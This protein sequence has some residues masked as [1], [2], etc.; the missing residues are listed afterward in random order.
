MTLRELFPQ[1]PV[2]LRSPPGSQ[3]KFGTRSFY[4]DL[5]WYAYLFMNSEMERSAETS[6][7]PEE[8]RRRWH[9]FLQDNKQFLIFH[10]RPLV[11]VYLW[12]APFTQKKSLVLKVNWDLFPDYLEDK[13]QS[14]VSEV[15][16]DG[17]NILKLYR[18]IWINFFGDVERFKEAE[19]LYFYERENFRKLL[20]RTGD[21][22]DL[23]GLL[24]SFEWT[25]HQIEKYAENKNIPYML[26]YTKNFLMDLQHLR[27][28]IDV[29][30]IPPAYLLLRSL[31]ENFVR[32][33]VY[34]RIGEQLDAPNLVLGAM[35]LYEYEADKKQRRYSFDEFKNVFEKKFLK[36][37]KV[38]LSD[39]EI[40]VS[41][42]MSKF[43]EKGIPMLGVN[44]DVLKDFSLKYNVTEANLDKLYSACSEV[45]HNQPPLPFFSLLEVKFFKHF[46][47]KCIGSLLL[48]SERIIYD[49]NHPS[50]DRIH[51]L[52]EGIQIP[53][54]PFDDEKIRFLNECINVAYVLEIEHV[55]EIKNFI[56][57]AVVTLQV[58]RSESADHSAT[59]IRPLSLISLFHIISPSLRRLRD[60]SL[61]EEDLGDIIEIIQTISFKVSIKYEIEATLSKLEDMIS[62]ELERY[63]VFSSLSPEKKKKVIFYLLINNLSRAL[64]ETLRS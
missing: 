23:V 19:S 27:A 62:P 21:Y 30:S 24:I 18:E 3:V 31:L 34:F 37:Q 6:L 15:E 47:G 58:E 7:I 9:E 10:N 20:K 16:N 5:P 48:L 28:L 2:G 25:I 40:D 60:F 44:P 36:L 57:R 39:T 17:R 26:F 32:L 49:W 54:R 45:I 42:V 52:V 22:I 41:E 4:V 14:L 35:F 61:I 12:N 1:Y 46:L 11:S 64:E 29:I 13:A 51:N 38:F 59:W 56:R 63:N 50:V 43:N 8:V 33:F 55:E 53:N